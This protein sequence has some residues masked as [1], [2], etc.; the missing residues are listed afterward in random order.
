MG[1]KTLSYLLRPLYYHHCALIMCLSAVGLAL[2]LDIV[3]YEGRVFVRALVRPGRPALQAIGNKSAAGIAYLSSP[4]APEHPPYRAM[5][6][7]ISQ[8]RSGG[9]LI[10]NCGQHR[11][12]S[13]PSSRP[14][15]TTAFPLFHLLSEGRS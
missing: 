5:N 1:P 7:E 12:K 14:R 6:R 2:V 9:I 13:I 11:T 15:R 8:Y 10:L 3:L 4:T